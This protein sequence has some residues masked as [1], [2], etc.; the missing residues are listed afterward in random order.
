MTRSGGRQLGLDQGSHSDHFGALSFGK[1]GARASCWDPI[2]H[3]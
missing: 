1:V 2:Q 3:W